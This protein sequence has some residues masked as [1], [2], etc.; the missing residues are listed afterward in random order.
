MADNA[1]EIF[2]EAERLLRTGKYADALQG[3]M[4]CVRALPEFWRARFRVADTLLNLE[5]HAGALEVYKSLAWHA[6][7]AGHPL[8]GLVATK[9]AA[10]MDRS[11]G[12]VVDV[13]AQ[14]YSRDSD[15]VDPGRHWRP[16]RTPKA[17]DPVAPWP[18]PVGAE[19]VTLAVREAGN[20]EAI[21][22][23]P[24]RLPAIPLFSFLDEGAFAS[25]LEGLQL[26]RFVTGQSIIEEGQPGDSFFILAEQS[27]GG[28]P[29]GFKG[30]LGQETPSESMYGGDK[31]L[32][33]AKRI[34][35]SAPIHQAGS[36][37]F[38]Q[39]TGGRFRECDRRNPLR[40]YET[41]IHPVRKL[42]FDAMGLTGT[43]AGRYK[44]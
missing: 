20:T 21:A 10:L 11:L 34:L 44:G 4:R 31:G 18:G 43:G 9:M 5:A 8:Q 6:I 2:E 12:E 15:R 16:R 1:L 28:T 36:N 26:R 24:D 38:A 19:L 35:H 27:G 41:G 33:Q 22:N 17:S 37:T 14:L 42:L 30:I 39:F 7:K 32:V 29:A 3:Y 40:A 23:Y 13:L 25:V